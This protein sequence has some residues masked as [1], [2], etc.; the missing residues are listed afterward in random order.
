MGKGPAPP[1]AR[2]DMERDWEG[3]REGC[4]ER[5]GGRKDTHQKPKDVDRKLTIYQLTIYQRQLIIKH[6]QKMPT[7]PRII[8]YCNLMR[9]CS[10]TGEYAWET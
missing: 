3:G 1:H 8:S 6:I 5:K 9:L 10:R 7:R 4:R 2:A